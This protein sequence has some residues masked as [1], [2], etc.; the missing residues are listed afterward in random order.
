MDR[1]PLTTTIAG[2]G[3]I[4]RHKPVSEAKIILEMLLG[5]L[6]AV[7]AVGYSTKPCLNTRCPMEAVPLLAA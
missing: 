3:D 6:R 2:C 5:Q 4:L 1:E 7:K